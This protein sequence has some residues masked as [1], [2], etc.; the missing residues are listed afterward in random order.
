VNYRTFTE[1]QNLNSKKFVD[2]KKV[3]DK[4]MTSNSPE[5]KGDSTH[6]ISSSSNNHDEKDR[7]RVSS[8]YRLLKPPTAPKCVDCMVL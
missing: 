6:P 3:L 4:N 7:T 1:F 8:G 5:L 2:N